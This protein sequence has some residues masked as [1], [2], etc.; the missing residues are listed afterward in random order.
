MS[1]TTLP[2]DFVAYYATSCSFDTRMVVP[3]WAIIYVVKKAKQLP[4]ISKRNI[5]L[6]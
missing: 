6:T 2:N 5:V 3:F 4:K 1:K